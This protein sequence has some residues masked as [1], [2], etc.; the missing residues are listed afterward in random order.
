[1]LASVEARARGQTAIPGYRKTGVRVAGPVD[2]LVR[3]S[4]G[5]QAS[6]TSWVG[7]SP[8]YHVD[9]PVAGVLQPSPDDVRAI[10]ESH[11][12][13]LLVY[14]VQGRR[15]IRVSGRY[16]EERERALQA[17]VRGA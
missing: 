11:C 12:E 5:L 17:L 2:Y 4:A 7:T 6:G 13:L 10:A 9:V 14:E 1:M 15:P 3:S 16:G 8:R